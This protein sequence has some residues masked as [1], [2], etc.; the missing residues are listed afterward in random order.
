MAQPT[1][2]QRLRQIR[3]GM[4]YSQ[5]AFADLL[6]YTRVHMGRIERD[7]NVPADA[8]I[9]RLAA[10]LNVTTAY[11]RGL[12][13]DPAGSLTEADLTPFEMLAIASSRLHELADVIDAA[14]RALAGAESRK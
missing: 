11:L 1:L 12:V 5:Q 2:G 9:E 13:E 4:G 14:L 7:M 10:K 6:G 3:M 8:D